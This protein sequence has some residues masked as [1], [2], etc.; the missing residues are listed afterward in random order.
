MNAK[1]WNKKLWRRLGVGFGTLLVIG[2]AGN[3]IAQSNAAAINHALKT[4]TFEVVKTG[5]QQTDTDYF[6]SS[7]KDAAS[8]KA[9]CAQKA[10]ETEAE[11]A[12]LLKNDNSAL[13]LKSGAKV[14]VFGTASAKINYAAS[15]SSSSTGVTYPQLDEVFNSKKMTV[16]PTLMKFYREGNG[17]KYGRTSVNLIGQINE[18][19]WS[20]YDNATL[21]SVSEYGDAA[22]V[23]LARDAGE[24]S[25]VAVTG[26]DGE[27]G[28][29]LSISAAESDL[30]KQLTALKQ[31]GTIKKIVVL[32]NTAVPIETDF[33]FRS[34]ISVDSCLWIGNVGTYGLA[35]VADLLVGDAVP[36]GSLDDTLLKDNFASPA[37]ASWILNPSKKF[38]QRYSNY[39]TYKLNT[40][41]Y[42]YAAYTEGV[43]VGYRYF[44]TR[45]EDKVMNTANVG[46]FD[47]SSSVSYPFGYG[48]SYSDFSYSGFGVKEN[49]SAFDVSVTITNKGTSYSGKKSVG[50]YL[51]KPYTDYDK[52][53]GIE[54][55]AVELVGFAKTKILAPGEQETQTISVPKESFKSYDATGAKTY[56]LDAGKYYLTAGESAHAAVN[57]I[58]ALKG[59]SKTN[60]MDEEG[61]AGLA[62]LALDQTSLDTS[63]YAVSSET[64]KAVANQL[65]FMD[66]NKYQNSG[67]NKVTYLSRSN[68]N[69]TWPSAAVSLAV[70]NDQMAYDL[71]SDK[72][73][74]KTSDTI[75]S[76]GI[77]S[78]LQLIS[79]RSTAKTKVAYDDPMWDKLLDQMTYG[80]QSLLMTSAG[81]STVQLPSIGKPATADNDGP[82]AI[83]GTKT[84][85]VFPSEGIWA[86]TFNKELLKDIGRALGE[87]ARNAGF[88]SMYAPGVNIHRVPFGGRLH[89][90]FSE[91]PYLTGEACVQEV[92]GM[93][94]KGVIPTV[95]HFAFNNEE[96][97]RNGIGIWMNEQ[98][99]REIMLKPYEMAVAPS[100]GNAHGI[101]TSFNRAGCIW[102]SASDH[103][104]INIMRDEFGFDGYSLT[105]MAA[106]NAAAYMLYSDGIYNG[107]SLYLGTGSETALDA[108]KTNARFCQRMRES[109]HR[110][111]YVICN[112]S[113]AMNGISSDTIIVTVT[114][115]WQKTLNGVIIASG[116]VT[117]VSA[118]LLCLSYLLSHKEQQ[119]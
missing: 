110:V 16:N 35:G 66:V 20:E 30:L 109:C 98:E 52:T 74:E 49:G 72:A 119:L 36:S 55:P 21:G 65:D 89:E 32:L 29:Y 38:S 57:N 34:E 46:D 83:V 11:G 56:I 95:K 107:T 111:L 117:G 88:Q 62:A 1:L 51:Q 63:T 100:Q 9:Y 33:L 61:Q 13:P 19:P 76:Y 113:A 5:T 26:S 48:L 15:G 99:A 40:T 23:V 112:F 93:Q 86:S 71:S 31:A 102:T 115:W 17:A 114:P 8:L 85:T 108:Y 70:A 42:A 24:G 101:M 103:L 87:D 53:N 58:L 54:K 92:T 12:V 28:S 69:G 43:Y 91:D 116:V 77:N 84:N 14:S 3:D 47:Y 4:S 6:A 37:M 68:W 78:G 104:M 96:T 73:M 79:L 80:E 105:D 82:T 118:V 25:D 41:Q 22:I 50:I 18:C 60:G 94:E 10:E 97:N 45:Y 90:Y 7:F 81:F 106:S 39:K 64:G 67:S 59:F 44:E 27:D 75:P 2:C